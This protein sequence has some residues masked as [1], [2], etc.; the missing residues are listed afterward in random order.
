MG[1]SSTGFPEM[2]QDT[3]RNKNKAPRFTKNT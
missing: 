2:R 3:K 1:Q